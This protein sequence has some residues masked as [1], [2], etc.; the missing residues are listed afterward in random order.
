M[1]YQI[2]VPTRGRARLDLQYTVKMFPA[3][4]RAMTNLVV[5]PDEAA[6]YEPIAQQLGVGLVLRPE[7]CANLS[8]T[9]EWIIHEHA[10]PARTAIM[11]DDDL[12]F[13]V[14]IDQEDPT[15]T[16]L[17]AA[18][19]DD[20]ATILNTLDELVREGYPMAGVSARFGNNNKK[21][22]VEYCGRQMQVH[23]VDPAFFRKEDIRPSSVICKSDFF[24]TLSVLTAG[25][26]NAI[27][28]WATVDQ[29]KGSNAE[30][31]VSVYRDFDTLNEGAERLRSFFPRYVS[32]VQKT[33][34]WKGI[35][36]PFNDVRIQW[37]K[38][39]NEASAD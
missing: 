7:T 9:L 3:A 36:R 38:A 4:I 30:G 19:E 6:S 8:Q 14:R 22:F 12:R 24:M 29:A 27:I 16:S 23:A 28:N 10:D 39:F 17:R 5:R 32:V 25:E 34:R 20:V 33:T 37:R 1:T 31:G 35:D 15:L 26:Q 2:Y 11:L 13:S 18:E 21:T